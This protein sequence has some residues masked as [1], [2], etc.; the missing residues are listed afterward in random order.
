MTPGSPSPF[1]PKK[2]P[3]LAIHLTTSTIRGG[4][5]GNDFVPF[6]FE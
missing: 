6:I 5:F 4:I 1:L 3:K 2:P